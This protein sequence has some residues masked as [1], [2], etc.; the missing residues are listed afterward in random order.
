MADALQPEPLDEPREDTGAGGD[1][2][3]AMNAI[4]GEDSDG[5]EPAIAPARPAPSKQ[6]SALLRLAQGK[7]EAKGP[8]RKAKLVDA[9]MPSKGV[10]KKQR[11]AKGLPEDVA[12]AA[13]DSE[14]DAEPEKTAAD[15][16]FIDDEG[17]AAP[18]SD[19]EGGGLG[20]PP[21]E[22][23]EDHGSEDE[24][25]AF[26]KPKGKR[27]R[28]RTAEEMKAAAAEATDLV[29]Q[30]GVAV[31][32][33]TAARAA[34]HLA[35][36]KLK[37][38]PEVERALCRVE[39]QL[40]CLEANVLGALA[41]WLR[42][43]PDGSLPNL[44]LRASLLGLVARL[45]V[46]TAEPERRE[47]LKRSGLGKVVMFYK[48]H[49]PVP[50]HRATAQRLVDAWARPIFSLSAGYARGGGEEEG[51]RYAEEP[52]ERAAA[53]AHEA[54]MEGGGGEARLQPGQP[55]Y[56]YH[57]VIPE[58]A[59]LDYTRRP[60]SRVSAAVSKAAP[61]LRGGAKIVKDL[62][63][64]KVTKQSYNALKVSVEGR[65]LVLKHN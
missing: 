64:K 4:F 32:E 1:D 41:D 11:R 39:L 60:E 63:N 36:A 21:E 34:G 12:V 52:E 57:A 55:G 59:R 56:R 3:A 14:D 31:D 28:Q 24:I 38:L 18:G 6:K 65:N 30:M 9:E 23:R 26:F 49:D 42:P 2:A 43:G 46:D 40:L 7:A 16:A 29:A 51:P 50:A 22:A 61:D 25:D 62:K 53:T 27:R 17:V 13:V 58:P 15:V 37:L 45:P 48:L 5:D 19:D 44:R 10:A 8:K 47:Q 33:D 35:V 20:P 54:D